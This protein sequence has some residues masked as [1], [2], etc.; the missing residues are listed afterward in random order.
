MTP[1][2]LLIGIAY[3]VSCVVA[4][5]AFRK[6]PEIENDH[7][8]SSECELRDLRRRNLRRRHSRLAFRSNLM[9]ARSDIFHAKQAAH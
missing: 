6:A 2:L 4:V 9:G 3:A 7:A 8:P 1:F 5:V